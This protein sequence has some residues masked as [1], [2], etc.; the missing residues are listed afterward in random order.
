VD[1]N[2]KKYRLL[3]YFIIP[4]VAALLFKGLSSIPN[5]NTTVIS[6]EDSAFSNSNFSNEEINLVDFN[7]DVKPILSDKCY[8][9]H[10]PDEKARKANLRLDIEDGFYASLKDSESHFIVNRNNP[11]E[12]EILKRINSE[13][14]DYLMPPPDSNLILSEKEKNI[15]KKWIDQGGKWEK[16]WSYN[17]PKLSEIPSTIFEDWTSNEIDYF[18]A[19]NLELKGLEPSEMEKK[20]ILLRRVSFDLIGLPPTIVEIDSFLLDKSILPFSQSPKIL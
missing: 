6:K 13:K 16:H 19:K 18:I 3:G 10:G 12:S 8:A 15:L 9:C 5:E 11:N 7:F 17:K 20:E 14:I 4:F 2:L 1:N